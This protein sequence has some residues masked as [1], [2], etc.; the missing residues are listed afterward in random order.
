MREEAESL[1]FDALTRG[2]HRLRDRPQPP[3]PPVFKTKP[4]PNAYPTYRHGMHVASIAVVGL[5]GP[6]STANRFLRRIILFIRVYGTCVPGWQR[7]QNS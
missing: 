5:R 4:R 3:M 1:I 6:F 7:R 2:R